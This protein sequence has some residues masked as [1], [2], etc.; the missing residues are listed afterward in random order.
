MHGATLFSDGLAEYEALEDG[1]GRSDAG[2]GGELSRGNLPERP[3][4]AG[5]PMTVPDAQ[6]LGAIG[7][8]FSLSRCTGRER[9]ATVAAIHEIADAVVAATA[10]RGVRR[11]RLRAMEG[12]PDSAS[13]YIKP[14]DDGEEWAVPAASTS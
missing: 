10:I 4:H 9:P 11:L 8:S 2:P 5:W 6:S 12:V 13:S 7:A 1:T 14:S 3:G